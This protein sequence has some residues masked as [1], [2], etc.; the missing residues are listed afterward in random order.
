[1]IPKTNLEGT[2]ENKQLSR[3]RKKNNSDEDETY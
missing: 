2:E 1:M 3:R